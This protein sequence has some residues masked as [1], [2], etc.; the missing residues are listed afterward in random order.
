MPVRQKMIIACAMIMLAIGLLPA[1]AAATGQPTAITVKVNDEQVALD[2]SPAIDRGRIMVPLHGVLEKLGAEVQWDPEAMKAVVTGGGHTMILQPG[3]SSA[4]VDGQKVALDEAAKV[5]EGHLLVPLRFLAESM[6]AKVIWIAD[7]HTVVILH[8]LT[9]VQ[10]RLFEAF[11]KLNQ[12]NSGKV[13]I[14]QEIKE[15]GSPLD[16]NLDLRAKVASNG[17]DLHIQMEISKTTDDADGELED[18]LSVEIIKKGDQVYE[19]FDDDPWEIA[20]QDALDLP[21]LSD[22]S[23]EES[24]L[25]Y[26]MLPYKVDEK[27]IWNG[28]LTTRYSVN[29]DKRTDSNLIDKLLGANPDSKDRAPS[30]SMDDSAATGTVREELYTNAINNIIQDKLT[31]TLTLAPDAQNQQDKSTTIDSTAQETYEY[32][33]PE[34]IQ[35]PKGLFPVA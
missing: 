29:L 16:V 5:S 9:P 32:S 30:P 24:Y 7:T 3:S 15:D 6:D 10:A 35:L 1:A 18:Q 4:T 13:V 12:S 27:F 28:E 2:T 26:Y 17:D 14:H 34:A 33:P 11:T 22:T 31:T 23:P 21:F 20:G 25:N 19:K 8:N